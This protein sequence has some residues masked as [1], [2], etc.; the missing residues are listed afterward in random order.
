MPVPGARKLDGGPVAASPPKSSRP[1]TFAGRVAPP[2]A[3]LTAR[4]LETVLPLD[5]VQAP[6][7]E[8]AGTGIWLLTV[9]AVGLASAIVTKAENMQSNRN[10]IRNDM[11]QN[12]DEFP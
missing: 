12:P 11:P 3:V 2:V 10:P 4:K 6:P 7:T 1:A 5:S 9:Q 8:N